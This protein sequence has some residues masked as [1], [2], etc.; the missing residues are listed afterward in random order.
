MGRTYW[1][2]DEC[3]NIEIRYTGKCFSCGTFGSMREYK[4]SKKK[5]NEGSKSSFTIGETTE[6]P[7]ILDEV[8]DDYLQ[9]GIISGIG[10]FDEACGGSITQGSVILVGGD[11]GNG[12]STL[13]TQV[14]HKVS[15]DYKTLYVSG[16]ES[17]NQIKKRVTERLNLSSNDNFLVSYSKDIEDIEGFVHKFEPKIL[18]IDSINTIGSRDL[19]GDPGDVGQ[20]RHTTNRVVNLAKSTGTTI[21]CVVQVTKNQQLSGPKSLEHMADTVFYLEGD[22]FNDL[23]LLRT[24]KNRFGSDQS[25]ACFRMGPSGMEEIPN[26]SEYLLQNRLKNSPGNCAVCISDS[27]PLLVEVQSLISPLMYENA[28]PRRT[29]VG[30]NRSRL[31]ILI[32]VLEKRCGVRGITYNDI[33]V[34]VVGGLS[35]DDPGTD[36]GVALSIYSA[37]EDVPVDED[38]AVIGEVGL[39]GEVRPVSMIEQLVKEA[40][41]VGFTRVVVP[42]S[43]VDSLEE[44]ELPIE[45]IPVR[46]VKET[47]EEIF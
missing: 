41:R 34:N 45:L 22:K 40:S 24:I 21:I 46:T 5:K 6:E 35:L 16:E 38:I 11:P 44:L 25:V 17:K 30:Y 47:I 3:G 2:C 27:R 31:N 8:S 37:F 23:R 15:L 18:V 28:T 7:S 14:L 13:L 43:S 19:D 1:L 32:A 26:P 33:F 4:K 29:S 10:E 9:S 42:V 39:S 20:M 36:L 12:K